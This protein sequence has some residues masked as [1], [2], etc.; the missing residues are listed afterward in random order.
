M[1]G[2]CR[3]IRRSFPYRGLVPAD[4]LAHLELPKTVQVWM[5]PGKHFVHYFVRGARL[6]N[7]VAVVEQETWSSESWT[8]R[9]KAAD[10]LRAFED[11]HPQVRAI[12]AAVDDTY[13]WAL[14]DRKPMARWS[15]G[16]LTLL[17]KLYAPFM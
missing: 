8:D 9:G 16:R 5:G 13:K 15:V 3:E 10:A 4:R 7:F 11:W 12:L 14:F 2:N 1:N 6:V 17:G